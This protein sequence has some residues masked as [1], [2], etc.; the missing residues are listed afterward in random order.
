MRLE[1]IWIV[2]KPT[3][4]ST[5]NDILFDCDIDRLYL[6]FL[7]GMRPHDVAGMFTDQL[8]AT[9]E[10]KILLNETEGKT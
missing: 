7:G 2:T 10:A 1:K 4:E 3:H 9:M 8:E 5:I 6:Q